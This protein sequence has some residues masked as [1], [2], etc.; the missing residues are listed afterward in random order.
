MLGSATEGTRAAFSQVLIVKDAMMAESPSLVRNSPLE[1][2]EALK[3]HVPRQSALGATAAIFRHFFPTREALEM[4]AVTNAL[5]QVSAKR[6]AILIEDER[7]S[8]VIL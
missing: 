5:R 6:N 3:L 2:A 8:E 7:E 1:T 4:P